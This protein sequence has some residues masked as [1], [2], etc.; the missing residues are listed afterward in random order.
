MENY[1]NHSAPEDCEFYNVGTMMNAAVIKML[2]DLG[3]EDENIMLMTSE[4]DQLPIK[5]NEWMISVT[6]VGAAI[7]RE[8]YKSAD[9][10]LDGDAVRI[11]LLSRCR[12]QQVLEGK[13]MELIT[14][15]ICSW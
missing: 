13:T 4:V 8:S 14:D 3:A 5:H 11:V 7:R 2:K 6:G 10:K 1:Q 15:L 9:D 12:K